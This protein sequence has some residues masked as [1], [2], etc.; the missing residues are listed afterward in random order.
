MGTSIAATIGL[1]FALVFQFAAKPVLSIFTAE[2]VVVELGV[3][4]IRSYVFDCI[5]AAIHFSFSGYFCAMGK[6]IISFIHNVISI[7]CV[8][9]PGA[10]IAAK[11]YPQ[12]L[13]PMGMAAP[14]GS[15]LSAIICVAAFFVCR[16]KMS[17]I[18]T[19]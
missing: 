10:Y 13:F 16:K 6:S 14:L 15:A 19:K 7:I 5:F 4:Y 18:E 12:T 17:L 2:D 1:I 3:Q 9:I 11:L 8:R